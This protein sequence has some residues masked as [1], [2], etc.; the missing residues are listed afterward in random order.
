MTAVGRTAKTATAPLL[1]GKREPAAAATLAQY[2]GT[3][4]EMDIKTAPSGE[5]R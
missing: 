5:S 1:F 2:A 3:D 4:T